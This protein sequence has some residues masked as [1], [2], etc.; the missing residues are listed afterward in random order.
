MKK[1]YNDAIT[2]NPLNPDDEECYLVL[3]RF[4]TSDYYS[5]SVNIFEKAFTSTGYKQYWNEAYVFS[6]S[7]FFDFDV[8]QLTFNLDGKY[9]VIPAVSDP[10]DVVNDGT[11]PSDLDKGLPD[12]LKYLFMVLGIIVLL[13]ILMPILPY[14]IKAVVW[15][16]MLPFKLI[17]AI[18]KGIQKAVK[19]KPKQADVSPPKA[20]QAKP[21]KSSKRK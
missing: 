18:V 13:V 16:I 4:A 10:I 11:P 1:A 19:K 7:I 20:V 2:V 17:A 3:F 6:Q 21:P 8:I 12:W 15:V 5:A 14:I 9:H